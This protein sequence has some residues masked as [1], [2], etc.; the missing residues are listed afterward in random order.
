LFDPGG[1]TGL[2]LVVAAGA[3]GVLVGFVLAVTR[4]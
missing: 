3:A 2:L 1:V 4:V